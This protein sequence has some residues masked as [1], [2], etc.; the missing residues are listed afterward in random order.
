MRTQNRAGNSVQNLDK[1]LATAGPS[2]CSAGD[3]AHTSYSDVT[4]APELGHRCSDG[5]WQDLLVADFVGVFSQSD[6]GGEHVSD[7][8]RNLAVRLAR[9]PL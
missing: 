2:S 1:G 5:Q 6:M 3:S 4:Y 8:R 9:E 7:I